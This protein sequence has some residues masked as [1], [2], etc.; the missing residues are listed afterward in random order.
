MEPERV[1]LFLLISLLA[2]FAQAQTQPYPSKDADGAKALLGSPR[3]VDKAWGAYSAAELRDNSLRD[4]L[5]DQLRRSIPL[6]ASREAEPSAYIRTL[7]DSL[8]QL[9]ADVPLEVILPFMV[10]WRTEALILLAL[11]TPSPEDEGALLKLREE[12]LD[13]AAWLAVNNLLFRQRSAALFRKTLEEVRF[14][15]TFTTGKG[16]G[17]GIAGSGGRGGITIGVPQGYPPTAVYQL[18]IRE[19]PGFRPVPDGVP[20]VKGPAYGSYDADVFYRATLVQPTRT[21]HLFPDYLDTDRQGYR[22]AYLAAFG[23]ITWDEGQK[24]FSPSSQ[25]QWRSARDFRKQVEAALRDQQRAI[26]NFVTAASGKNNFPH[27]SGVRLA[28][29]PVLNDR[30]TSPTPPLPDIPAKEFLID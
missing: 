8:I 21:A 17:K 3:L 11:K 15:H 28:I 14:T 16:Q 18:A 25:L 9:H 5:I 6:S 2:S 7:F 22:R 13:E 12:R 23:G 19:W 20:L 29:D 30:R 4:A 24:L 26:L 1:R 10:R 27:P